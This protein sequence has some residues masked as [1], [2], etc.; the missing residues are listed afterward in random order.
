MDII[1][2]RLGINTQYSNQPDMN[3][4]SKA[5]ASKSRTLL[6]A[7]QVQVARQDQ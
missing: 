2:I 3:A 5:K 1:R 4:E 6:P 7:Y